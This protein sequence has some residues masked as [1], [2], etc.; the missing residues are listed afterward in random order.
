MSSPTP[1]PAEAEAAAPSTTRRVLVLAAALAM[2]W[3]VRA[4]RVHGDAEGAAD[5][6]TL[7]ACGFVLLAAFTVGELG[8]SLGLPK[9]TGYILAGALVGPQVS[10]ILSQRVVADLATFNTLALGLIATSA[11]LELNLP[12][13]RK[14]AR[15]L[16]ATVVAKLAL[17]PLLVGLPLFAGFH[18]LG[19]LGLHDTSQQI[20]M[21]LLFSVLGIGTSPAIALA[22]IN[23]TG[24]RGRLSDLLLAMAV[25]K[26]LV[27]VTS[28]A[29]AIPVSHALLSGGGFDT[30]ALTHLAT[31][32]GASV[33]A[34][35]SV[36]VLLILYFRFVG[37]EPLFSALVAIL[38]V[39][40]ASHWLH[41]ELLLVFIVAGFVVRNFSPY[42]HDLLHPIERI[43]L[44]VFVVFFTAA[45]AAIDLRGT[46][47]I[48]PVAV[49]LVGLR[50]ATFWL[51]ARFGAWAG[52]EPRAVAGNAWLTYLP[53]AGVTLGLVLLAA[54]NVHELSE[55]ITRLGMAVVALN[56]LVG[57]VTLTVALRRSGET[58]DA[59]AAEPQ[60]VRPT[61]RI[62]PA[63]Q[64]EDEPEPTEAPDPDALPEPGALA[65]RLD[66]PGLGDA[67]EAAA[68]EVVAAVRRFVADQ[69]APQAAGLAARAGALV[70][71][72]P[73]ERVP[74][75][76]QVKRTLQ[77]PPP[78]ERL[79]L[80]RAGATL[81]D[82]IGASL[83]GQRWSVA[84]P[85]DD[86][87]MALGTA[88]G[89][90]AR[91][92]RTG[93]VWQRRFARLRRRQPMR[94]V[95][96]QLTL[97]IA[98]E[99]RLAEALLGVAS[100]FH[101]AEAELL[102]LVRA[103]AQGAAEPEPERAVRIAQ[104]WTELAEHE[105]TSAVRLGLDEAVARLALAGGPALPARALRFADVEQQVTTPCASSWPTPS[106][107]GAASPLPRTPSAPPC[108]PRRS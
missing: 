67:A 71:A 58:R 37:I 18:L 22:V 92:R 15:T 82:E 81:F 2:M 33:G 64:A 89:W 68:A 27:V 96:L 9:V 72:E 79:A 46:L 10:D 54:E 98:L 31:E 44:P 69:L 52:G 59:V 97:R 88:A 95:P 103:V 36:G 23:D 12:A 83:R 65:A 21:A 76:R 48:L 38:L 39:A 66:D 34:G 45:G 63:P 24:A 29:V 62:V 41:L 93:A 106:P 84:A 70:A 91:V 5:P 43:A 100:S 14:V 78:Y 90:G 53:Q 61:P 73:R 49:G 8:A 99:P 47:A 101:R 42:E 7:A 56:L 13:I 86:T 57:P 20:V 77:E 19:L 104:R 28:L 107:G 80:D 102:A 3:G 74:W 35:V 1:S 17:L 40:E 11:G 25:V 55:P 6:L 94:R 30:H 51:A 16:G 60:P 75:L 32:L 26:D 105:L 108:S 50:A 4:L 85:L 87:A